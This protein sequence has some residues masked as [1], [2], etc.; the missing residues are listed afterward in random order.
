MS[1]GNHSDLISD[2]GPWYNPRGRDPLSPGL[3]G[4]P[5]P[6][7]HTAPGGRHRKTEPE[8][9]PEPEPARKIKARYITAATLTAL[10]AVPAFWMAGSI[11]AHTGT[12]DRPAVRL[13]QTAYVPMMIDQNG[14][15]TPICVYL[16]KSGQGW[17]AWAVTRSC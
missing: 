6:L 9:I 13:S 11:A 8:P 16:T 5:G 3:D 12:E 7:P 4:G 14:M 1:R 2:S 17:K 15:K 10:L